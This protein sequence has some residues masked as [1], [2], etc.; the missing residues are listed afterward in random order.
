MIRIPIPP[1]TFFIR[2]GVLVYDMGCTKK[3]CMEHT[4]HLVSALNNFFGSLALEHLG[5]SNIRSDNTDFLQISFSQTLGIFS[6][7]RTQDIIPQGSKYNIRSNVQDWE[8]GA[9]MTH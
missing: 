1:L 8:K 4:S 7:G 5:R 6:I 2:T 3:H 9:W